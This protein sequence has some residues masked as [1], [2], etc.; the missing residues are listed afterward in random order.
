MPD[1]G[2]AVPPSV[3]SVEG[4]VFT[5]WSRSYIDVSEG[6][7]IHAQFKQTSFTVS[8]TINGVLVK[9]QTVPYGGNATLP[10]G[11]EIRSA[12]YLLESDL[13]EYE[14]QAAGE[15]MA[16]MTE[17]AV[18]YGIG[19]WLGIFL[20]WED[21]G[22]VLDVTSDRIVA[23]RFDLDITG[24][25][26]TFTVKYVLDGKTI[27]KERVKKGEDGEGVLVY[28]PTLEEL[29]KENKKGYSFHWNLKGNDYTVVQPGEG[30][31]AYGNSTVYGEYLKK[32]ENSI[33][34]FNT[35]CLSTNCYAYAFDML[36]NPQTG[37]EFEIA[38][39]TPG[40]IFAMQPGMWSRDG[41]AKAAPK[42][43]P[44]SFLSDRKSFEKYLPEYVKEDAAYAGLKFREYEAGMSNGYRVAL[45]TIQG[46]LQ[47]DGFN[48]YA[49]DYHWMRM[50]EGGT[51]SSKHGNAEIQ[52]SD[53]GIVLENE[54][55]LK[56]IT[57]EYY[58]NVGW[59]DPKV[60]V[61]GIYYITER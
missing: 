60:R 19:S 21:E 45:V 22:S 9:S 8:F 44:T 41:W 58:H 42:Y 49:W 7:D 27:H 39:G 36:R 4:K 23:A 31:M 40:N 28:T 61:L 15:P 51:W 59:R 37:A 2:D 54:Q 20:G 12:G 33:K 1:G 47:K 13:E 57:E 48:I 32:Q 38:N 52:D 14:E 53:I 50:D 29:N 3:P 55:M 35:K 5:G 16:F 56:D 34:Q 25:F 24:W 10:T 30:I 6:I 17:D 18:P 11:E 26:N 43:T 46:S